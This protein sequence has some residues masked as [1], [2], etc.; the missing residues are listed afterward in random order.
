MS[1]KPQIGDTLSEKV[2]LATTTK[3]TIVLPWK[4]N[5]QSNASNETSASQPGQNHKSKRSISQNF[6]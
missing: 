3:R 5:K 1:S 6:R 2:L 4:V